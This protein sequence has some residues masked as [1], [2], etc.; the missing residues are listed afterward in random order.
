LPPH[1]D[2]LVDDTGD[3]VD[4]GPD[5]VLWKVHF[6]TGHHVVPWNRLRYWGPSRAGRFD[7]HAGSDL[8]PAVQDV[9]VSYTSAHVP[10]A[11]AEVFQNRRTINTTEGAPYMT[12]WFPTRP[13]RVLDLTGTWPIRNGASHVINTGR[14]DFTRAWARAIYERWPA[15]DGVMH[16]SKMTG[17]PCVCLWTAAAD[18]FPV[19]PSFARALA[20]PSIRS[21]MVKSSDEVG[22]RLH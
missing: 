21:L 2:A 4:I 19:A 6:T 17:R 7:P 18:S 1:P 20:D 15:V 11:L 10:S 22:F 13:L 9:G 14:T 3:W 8:E 5:D 12:G 16:A